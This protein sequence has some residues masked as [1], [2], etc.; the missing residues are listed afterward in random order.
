MSLVALRKIL[1]YG[2][3][4]FKEEHLFR[5]DMVLKKVPRTKETPEGLLVDEYREIILNNLTDRKS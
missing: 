2:D 4:A 5:A 3:E 1:K